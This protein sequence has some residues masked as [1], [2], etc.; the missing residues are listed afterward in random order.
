MILLIVLLIV[1]IVGKLNV[2]LGIGKAAILILGRA[3]A[4]DQ[5]EHIGQE[6][7]ADGKA[8]AQIEGLGQVDTA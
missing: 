6:Q 5:R 1:L 2:R 8:H 3:E 4:Q 7:Q